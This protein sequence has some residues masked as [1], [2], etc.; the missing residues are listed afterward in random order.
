MAMVTHMEEVVDTV[1]HMVE[2]AALQITG[3]RMA[4]ISMA[5]DMEPA[6]SSISMG[7]MTR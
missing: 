3:T 5:M 1:I 6:M 2:G 4:A 7:S